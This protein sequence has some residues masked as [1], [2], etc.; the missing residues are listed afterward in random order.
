MTF[1]GLSLPIWPPLVVVVGLSKQASQEALK[2][3]SWL[4]CFIFTC[5]EIAHLYDFDTLP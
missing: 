1:G 4:A 5:I 3:A 2:S